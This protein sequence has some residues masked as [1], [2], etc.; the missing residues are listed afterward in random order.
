MMSKPVLRVHHLYYV[1]WCLIHA[2]I[3]CVQFI[4]K[5]LYLKFKT[6]RSLDTDSHDDSLVRA[7]NKIPQ[8]IALCVNERTL[9]SKKLC[10]LIRWCERFRVRYVSLYSHYDTFLTLNQLEKHLIGFETNG[11]H[12]ET[13]EEEPL[14]HRKNGFTNTPMNG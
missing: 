10:Q 4:H 8:H 2:I 3:S 14:T 1:L 5:Y 12:K 11:R 6:K 7:L 9:E 13:A